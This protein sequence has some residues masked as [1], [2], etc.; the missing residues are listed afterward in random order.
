LDSFK[1]NDFTYNSASFNKVYKDIILFATWNDNT[2]GLL[3]VDYKL[4]KLFPLKKY[5][6]DD[7]SNIF[8]ETAWSENGLIGIIMES[9]GNVFLIKYNGLDDFIFK[10]ISSEDFKSYYKAVNFKENEFILSKW[11]SSFLHIRV[12]PESLEISILKETWYSGK[13]GTASASFFIINNLILFGIVESN[14]TIF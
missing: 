2:I 6:L 8:Y 10:N 11:S 1:V 7:T 14:N 12:D 5:T 3:K 9:E 4:E 13:N